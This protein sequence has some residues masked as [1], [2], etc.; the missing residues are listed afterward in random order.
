MT[1]KWV[2]TK[3]RV[4]P[5]NDSLCKWYHQE[6]NRGHKDFQS[7]ALP[8]ELW[9]HLCV[10]LNCGCKGMTF[11]LILQ[12]FRQLFLHFLF[13]KHHPSMLYH[14]STNVHPPPHQRQK[15]IKI[16][17]LSHKYFLFDIYFIS[18]QT[19]QKKFKS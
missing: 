19:L 8:T 7:F 14:H 18:L 13:P 6:S 3:K 1:T 5:K 15:H 17:Y 4:I 9:H 12:I 10:L 2:Q 16:K 11:F